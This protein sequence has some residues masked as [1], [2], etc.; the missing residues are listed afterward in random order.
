[1]LH[2]FRNRASGLVLL[3]LF[4]AHLGA[5]TAINHVDLATN[6]KPAQ[7]AGVTTLGGDDSAFEPIGATISGNKLY[8]VTV[9]GQVII[10]TDSIAKVWVKQ[11]STSRTVGLVV[12]LAAVGVAFV[13]LAN[14]TA[15]SYACKN[16]TLVTL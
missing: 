7:I 12:V 3:A 6:P 14:K 1:M 10:P 9:N 4:V 13:A 5:C 2:C 11:A 15:N 16:C 8:A